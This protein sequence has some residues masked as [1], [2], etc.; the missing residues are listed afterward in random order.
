MTTLL[1]FEFPSEGPFG[2][3]A[4]AAYADLAADISGEDGLIWKV[5]TEQPE[6]ATAGGVYLFE[7]AEAAARYVHKH[8]ARLAGFGITDI[9]AKEFVVNEALSETTRAVLR[10]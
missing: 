3:A 2:E 4:S 9:T 5:W 10:R 7:N 8:T 1:Y 6:T